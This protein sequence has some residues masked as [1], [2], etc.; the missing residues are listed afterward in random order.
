MPA[1]L[2][3]TTSVS[4]AFGSGD[5]A[6]VVNS[7]DE[8]HS[9]PITV[10][11][12]VCLSEPVVIV[13]DAVSVSDCKKFEHLDKLDE[14]ASSSASAC[15]LAVQKGRVKWFSMSG[16]FAGCLV[17]RR[18]ALYRLAK[19]P[20]TKASKWARFVCTPAKLQEV[21]Q[22]AKSSV[23]VRAIEY[24]HFGAEIPIT[25]SECIAGTKGVPSVSAYVK[26]QVCVIK[27]LSASTQVE[28]DNID[29]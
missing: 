18:W 20:R 25:V 3:P 29:R 9:K 2:I 8:L 28:F 11:S 7:A 5:G 14:W 22:H 26:L 17:C 1:A 6:S 27:G 16:D 23:H 24:F 15:P 13:D 12:N 10:Q 4:S 21:M 19:N